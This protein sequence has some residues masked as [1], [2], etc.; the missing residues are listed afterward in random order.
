MTCRVLVTDDARLDLEDICHYVADHDSIAQ[1]ERIADRILSLANTLAE[2]PDRGSRPRELVALGLTQYRQLIQP[3]WR[4]IY[5]I[6]DGDIVVHLIADSRR[7]MGSLLE[8]R[9]LGG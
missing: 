3:P 5:S 9:L 4:V 6:E 8:Q 2:F 7:D 1:A